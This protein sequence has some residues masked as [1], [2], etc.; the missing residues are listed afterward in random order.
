M[1]VPF[2]AS[3]FYFVL[4]SE[5]FFARVIYGG[6]KVFT[7]VWPILCV[8]LIYRTVFP[9]IQPGLSAHRKAI[10]LG[11]GVGMVIVVLLFVLMQ[12]ALGDVVIN[13]TESIK[14][15]ARELGILDYYWPFA[16]FLSIIHSLIEE[17][18]WRWFLF[19]H[20]RKVVRLFFAHILAG[21]SFAAHHVVVA[22]Q[23]FPIIWGFIFGGLVGLGGIIWS[24]MYEKQRSLIGAWICHT[25]VDLGIFFIGHKLLFGSYF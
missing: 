19:G 25:I 18:Y 9:K 2:A 5:Y 8:C 11:M 7:L 4:F 15:K 14:T 16:L 6:T 10:P 22:S 13:S 17:Y 23:F 3:L 12:T 24:L 20:L 1:V 21:V